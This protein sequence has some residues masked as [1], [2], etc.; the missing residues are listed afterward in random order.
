MTLFNEYYGM[1]ILFIGLGVSIWLSCRG[2]G[3]L[4]YGDKKLIIIDIEKEGKWKQMI[5]GNAYV[6]KL[7]L[8]TSLIWL[9]GS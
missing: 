5:Y 6:K 1:G 3:Y 7:N 8:E 4:L 9:K 2:I